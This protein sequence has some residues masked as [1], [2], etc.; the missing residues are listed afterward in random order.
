VNEIVYHL[1]SN[2][3]EAWWRAA[4]HGYTKD[5]AEAGVYSEQEAIRF[6]VRSSH[7]GLLS[8]VTCMVA[9]PIGWGQSSHPGSPS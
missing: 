5:R 4:A 9:V 2:K 1:W 7:C 8:G 6:V 3:H